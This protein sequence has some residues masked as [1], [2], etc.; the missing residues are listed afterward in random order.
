MT[1]LTSLTMT[2][3]VLLASTFATAGTGP[4]GNVIADPSSN[5][6]AFLTQPHT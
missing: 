1:G 3:V 6:Q 2:E 5:Q 4:G